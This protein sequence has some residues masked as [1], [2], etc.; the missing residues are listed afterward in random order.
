V[1][2]FSG[3][4]WLDEP[5]WLL[6][7]EFGRTENFPPEE[8]W[9]ITGVRIPTNKKVAETRIVTTR[10]GREFEFLGVSGPNAPLRDQ[11]TGIRP[12]ANFHLRTPFP[13]AE[14]HLFLM[15]IKDD[16]GRQVRTHGV[17]TAA[18]I[19]GGATVKHLLYGFA[20]DLPD[21]AKTLDITLAITKG[22]H[23]QF[24]AKPTLFRE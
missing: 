18:S 13:L 5:A 7:V 1:V 8:L 12:H 10:S 19:L 21:D 16:Q 17:C 11:F 3:G 14:W 2:D 15:D 22:R 20:F 6:N 4:L 24:V 23:V 9:L